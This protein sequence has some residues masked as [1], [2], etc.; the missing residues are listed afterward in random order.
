MRVAI[1]ATYACVAVLY[2]DAP[3]FVLLTAAI[4]FFGFLV[5]FW[6]CLGVLAA[7]LGRRWLVWVGLSI[8]FGPLSWYPVYWKMQGEVKKAL[9]APHA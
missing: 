4:L 2:I 8:I 7:R 3:T 9:L 5:S 1:Y 6:I